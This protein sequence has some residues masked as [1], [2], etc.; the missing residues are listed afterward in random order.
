ES[1]IGG[2]LALVQTGDRIRLSVR[3]RSISLLVS[4]EE[5]ARRAK[6]TNIKSPSAARGYHKFFL[7]HVL[8]ADD[9]VDFDFLR[10]NPKTE[11]SLTARQIVLLGEKEL[12]PALW[13]LLD[14]AGAIKILRG[15]QQI[16]RRGGKDRTG[17]LKECDQFVLGNFL[18]VCLEI[19]LGGLAFVFPD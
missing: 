8:Q 6:S 18:L 19:V 4:D 17:L 2:P 16:L 14:E 9:G 15:L 5:L 7:D 12:L 10:A 3:D 13:I 1:A 11:M